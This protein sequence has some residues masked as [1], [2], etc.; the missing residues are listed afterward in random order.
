MQWTQSF[1]LFVRE[2]LADFWE[3]FL[4]AYWPRS[5]M[6]GLFQCA[7]AVLEFLK[8][9]VNRLKRTP[10]LLRRKLAT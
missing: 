10:H 4:S 3:R 7:E 9:P 5:H 8:A 2:N 6:D 1:P